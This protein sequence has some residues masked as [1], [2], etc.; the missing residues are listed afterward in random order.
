VDFEIV[1]GSAPSWIN[2]FA[3]RENVDLIILSSHGRSGL[4]AWKVSS[5]ALKIIQT[6]YRSTMIVRA[7]HEVQELP[8][9]YKRILVPLDGSQRA[10]YALS[11]AA[12]L[13]AHF[14][15]ELFLVHVVGKPEVPRRAPLSPEEEGLVQRI[16][17]LN[18]G[19]AKKYLKRMA[20]QLPVPAQTQLYEND[21]VM[22]ALQ[23]HVAAA[24]VD[25]VVLCAHGY[26]GKGQPL[27]SVPM[28][29][30]L[31]GNTPL[32]ILQDLSPGIEIS[33]R[34][35]SQEQELSSFERR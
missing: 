1:D 17:E 20:S 12:A 14:E 8:I 11:T 23:R 4:G 2:D 26:S 18:K 25:L 29:F 22:E 9:L 13:A 21:D 5:V 10:E 15:A 31:Y 19:S 33:S 32:L 27:G 6:S 24:G 28:N 16:T 7:S 3:Q 34:S 35:A 30:I